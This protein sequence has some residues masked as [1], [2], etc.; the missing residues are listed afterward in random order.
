MKKKSLVHA[1]VPLKSQ[2]KGKGKERGKGGIFWHRDQTVRRAVPWNA[3]ID[4]L[5]KG[6][7]KGERLKELRVKKPSCCKGGGKEV[8]FPSSSQC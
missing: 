1:G 2:K 5:E 7:K 3:V 8:G 4:C 6:K